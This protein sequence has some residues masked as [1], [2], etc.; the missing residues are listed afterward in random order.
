MMIFGSISNKFKVKEG[1]WSTSVES[2][3]SVDA[4]DLRLARRVSEGADY[5]L[6]RFNRVA[7]DYYNK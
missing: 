4:S 7:F 2:V 3:C 5:R 1:R 6:E